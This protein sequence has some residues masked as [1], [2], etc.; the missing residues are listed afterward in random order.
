MIKIQNNQNISVRLKTLEIRR[1]FA[2]QC[3]K[4]GISQ[5]QFIAMATEAY[6]DNRL[7]IISKPKDKPSYLD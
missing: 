1:A 5:A 4:D 7:R 2:N 6:L 3:R